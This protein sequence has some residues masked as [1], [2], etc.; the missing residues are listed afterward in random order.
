MATEVAKNCKYGDK[1]AEGQGAIKRAIEKLNKSL[2][3]EPEHD[4]CVAVLRQESAVEPLS[5]ERIEFAELM[6]ECLEAEQS[7]LK[8]MSVKL[9]SI[10]ANNAT[11]TDR[12]RRN[13]FG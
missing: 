1:L 8:G 3:K 10:L 9:V 2:E 6:K 12:A 11:A 5:D 7:P 4:V 13:P